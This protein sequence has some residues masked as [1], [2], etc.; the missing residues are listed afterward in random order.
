MVAEDT[1]IPMEVMYRD[2]KL[3]QALACR[4]I[5]E[6]ATTTSRAK[7]AERRTK[8]TYIAIAQS[9]PD[10]SHHET[11]KVK[12]GSDSSCPQVHRA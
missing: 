9:C 5:T 10:S 4:S 6:P 11:T 7:S 1:K 2:N 3:A 12:M 8:V